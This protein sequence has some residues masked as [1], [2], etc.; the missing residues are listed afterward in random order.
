MEPGVPVCLIGCPRQPGRVCTAWVKPAA[1]AAWTNT[2]TDEK[3]TLIPS[4]HCVGGCGWH[5]Y[6]TNGVLSDA[7]PGVTVNVTECSA[8]GG[9]HQ[10][11]PAAPITDEERPALKI[12]PAEYTHR[13]TCPDTGQP[14]FA[15]IAP[16][17]DPSS[18][19]ATTGD[20]PKEVRVKFPPFDV[21]ALR[22]SGPRIRHPN[23]RSR[24]QAEVRDVQQVASYAQQCAAIAAIEVAN[25][26]QMAVHEHIEK[27]LQQTVLDLGAVVDVAI[28]RALNE[29][30]TWSRDRLWYR[31]AW[32]WL[33][34]RV[35]SSDPI[36]PVEGR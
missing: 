22:Q 26:G 2:G 15:A 3:P 19:A 25:V 23:D 28:N 34:E 30:D 24:D 9:N 10:A 8:C 33:R 16:S 13:A 35:R 11:L 32:K 4:Y 27:R 17:A 1:D 21:F 14:L 29:Y 5:G 7:P 18:Q 6:V 36:P 12:I 20:A 31:R